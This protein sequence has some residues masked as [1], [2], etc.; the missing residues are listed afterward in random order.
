MSDTTL[1]AG[2][3]PAT[4]RPSAWVDH[5]RLAGKTSASGA[6]PPAQ[7]ALT[8]EQLRF[9]HTNGYLVLRD[10]FDNASLDR[11][12]H[13]CQLQ[14]PLDQHVP[15][16]TYPGPGRWTLA[17]NAMSD[18]D[19]AFLAA[20]PEMVEPM[21]AVLADDPKII[22][23]AYYDRTPGGPGL[24]S[25]ND[26]K[27]WRPIG[28]SMRWAF[29]IVPLCDFNEDAGTLEFAPGS[30]L[31]THRPDEYAPVWNA[32]RP[33]RPSED[34]FIDP[35][36]RRGDLA[37]V[38]MHTWHR[39][40]NNNAAHHRTG[41]FTKWCAATQ[42]PATGWYPFIDEVR[43]G[44][45]AEG[46]HILGFSSPLAIQSTAALIERARSSG[47]QYLVIDKDGKLAAPEGPAVRELSI[48]DWD[49]GNYMAGLVDALDAQVRT[50]PTWMS[51]VGDFEHARDHSMQRVYGYR[52]PSHAW[53]I[54]EPGTRWL[55]A[56]ELAARAGDLAQPW[57]LQAIAEWQRADVV[58]GKAVT[59]AT[60]R[61]DQYAC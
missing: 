56:A 27:R 58:R 16:Q 1:I 48:P 54:T 7:P 4:N 26:Y 5:G 39:A 36:L 17:R 25:H 24:P 12:E 37:I 50:R 21:R 8:D 30:H 32:D 40:G 38:D 33:N 6:R 49:D 42:P 9:F 59:Q 53:G 28:S 29:A 23:W 19:V 14:P 10:V 35:Q 34:A 55:D 22:M 20:R 47:P 11:F 18:P 3:V 41:L 52:Q 2:P 51:Y 44:L 43:Q 60:G 31:V 13:A 46:E 45:G 57:L 15:N 61:A